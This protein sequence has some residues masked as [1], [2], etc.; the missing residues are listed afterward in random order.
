[1]ITNTCL[2]AGSFV[3][4]ALAGGAPVSAFALAGLVGAAATGVLAAGAGVGCSSAGG[5]SDSPASGS[6]AAVVGVS[7]LGELCAPSTSFSGA[8]EAEYEVSAIQL[9]LLTNL[10]RINS[11]VTHVAYAVLY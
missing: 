7:A 4:G 1:M 6:E 10:K 11:H 2:I 5:G 3:L 9:D 8:T